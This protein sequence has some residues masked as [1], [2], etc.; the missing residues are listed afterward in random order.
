[1]ESTKYTAASSPPSAMQ[2]GSPPMAAPAE[3]V[4][5][6]TKIASSPEFS[7]SPFILD[8]ALALGPE[9]FPH[10]PRSGTTQVPATI[11]NVQYLLESYGIRARYNTI[12]KNLSIRVPGQSGAPDNADNSAMSQV[13][14]LAALNGL[15]T[16][17]IPNYVAV[18][19]D[20]N[21]YNPVAE[22]I[23]STPWDGI[24]RL[25]DLY[26]TLIHREDYP[27]Q[28]KQQL[29]YRWL[30]SAVAAA[31]LPSGFKARGVL[32]FQ[33]P[34]S[35]GKTAWVTALMPDP[36]L[37]EHTIK[38]DHHLDA[39]NKDSLLTAISHWIVE[40]GELDSSFK[41]DIARLKGF[42][43]SDR[44][45]VRRPY[46]RTDSEYPR[47][48]IFCATVNDFNFLVDATGN[49]RW[50][51]I[52]VT[53]INYTHGINMQQVFAQVAVD[54]QNGAHW[55]LTQAEERSL[56]SYNQQHRT[57]SAIRDRLLD[58]IDTHKATDPD[59]PAMTA[60]A[61]LKEI[62]VTNP[63]NPNCKECA[64]V[65]RELFGEPKRI[66]GLMK[67][68]IPLIRRAPPMSDAAISGGRVF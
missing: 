56:E 40:I 30:V 64:A 61:M 43:T 10:P 51:T 21:Q 53:K 60:I 65:L 47:R 19:G 36:V 11:A 22:W 4:A 34:Q 13:I 5:Q 67:W 63:T 32:T 18:V 57:I 39:G 54:F 16:G 24:D 2:N 17:Q 27:E 62:G 50:W 25:S 1:M 49:S 26:N 6:A 48:T 29:I 33:G 46:G 3:N 14:S 28:L 31:L 58:V 12:R 55:W 52:P 68:R 23:T 41:K 8:N 45:K 20:R 7:E 59:L 66:N 42:L 9:T 38:L 44:D 35:I 15:P 37:R